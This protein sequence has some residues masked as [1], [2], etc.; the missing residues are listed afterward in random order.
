MKKIIYWKIV[1]CSIQLP[2][3]LFTE[4]M[5]KGTYKTKKFQGGIVY[6]EEE[7]PNILFVREWYRWYESEQPTEETKN[8]I[9]QVLKKLNNKIDIILSHT[10]LINI[11]L[12][13][14]FWVE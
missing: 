14:C 12:E 1:C 13:K 8:K 7:Y 11:Y 5:K 3:V 10:V 2:F 6:Y 9:R 4:I